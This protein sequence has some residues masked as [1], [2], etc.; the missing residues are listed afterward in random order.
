LVSSNSL[1]LPGDWEHKGFNL[2]RLLRDELPAIDG[3]EP[4]VLMHNDDVVQELSEAPFMQDV[5]HWGVMTVGTGLGDARF[6]NR[7]E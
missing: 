6:T 1:P 7:G 5:E 4:S 2:P 3:H